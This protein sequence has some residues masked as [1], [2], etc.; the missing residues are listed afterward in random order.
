MT[1][2][3]LAKD[4]AGQRHYT[5]GG[6]DYPSVSTVGQSIAKPGLEVWKRKQ[7]AKAI[8]TD[9]ELAA[10]AA[11]GDEQLLFAAQRNALEYNSDA[12]DFGTAVH[13]AVE[14]FEATGEI[15]T[16][17]ADLEVHANVL[18]SVKN[19]VTLKHDCGFDV[20]HVE[21][22]VANTTVGY[23]GTLDQ[24]ISFEGGQLMVADLKTG[25][26]DHGIASKLG[27]YA[28]QLAAYAHAEGWV[29]DDGNLIPFHISEQPSHVRAAVI[30]LAPDFAELWFVELEEAWHALRAQVAIH[31]S[32][33]RKGAWANRSWRVDA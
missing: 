15:A 1:A 8:A 20:N 5:V 27:G 23:A 29:N 9:P 6:V 31:N 28:Y 33:K 22:T 24:L 2:P 12:A 14:L 7:V 13:A 21:R 18:L 10:L 17:V 30:F 3:R 25:K 16:D 4:V 11:S 19:Y 26:H 32:E